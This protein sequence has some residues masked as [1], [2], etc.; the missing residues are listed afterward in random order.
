MIRGWSFQPHSQ[1]SSRGEGWESDLV[2]KGQRFNQSHLHNVAFK[3]NPR[4]RV[5]RASRLA[6]RWKCWEGGAPLR[7]ME[8]LCASPCL[9]DAVLHLAV[10]KWYCF[11][12]KQ[13]SSK[14]TVFL[15]SVSHC[16]KQPDPRRYLWEAPICS[17]GGSEAQVTA[18]S[19]SWCL[20]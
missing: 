7:G 18:W 14:E 15:S 12:I 5:R 17:P 13:K 10:L 16:S 19:C 20:W 4:D 9:P 1:T 6:N 3:K 2:A 8:A 11:T